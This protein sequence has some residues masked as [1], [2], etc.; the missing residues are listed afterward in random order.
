MNIATLTPQ[1]LRDAANLQERIEALQQQ[2][3]ELLAGEV[4]APAE[5]AIEAPQG[6]KHGRRRR[7]FSAEARAK[8]AA[9]QRARWAAKKR[10]GAR[11]RAVG[12][13]AE[14]WAKCCPQE[15]P[16]GGDEGEMGEAEE[17]GQVEA[18]ECSILTR[19]NAPQRGLRL[20]ICHGEGGG[21]HG[22]RR[23]CRIRMTTQTTVPA[24]NKPTTAGSIG[25][26]RCGGFCLLASTI[27]N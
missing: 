7:K 1:Q 15:G 9:S 5:A 13:N 11:A 20:W 26:Q 27:E 12:G 23:K 21:D 24:G 19:R 10:R 6:P 2:L 17:G 3:N 14:S 16:L 22:A 18:V 4:S 25:M 8:M